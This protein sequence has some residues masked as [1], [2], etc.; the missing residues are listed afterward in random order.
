MQISPKQEKAW[1]WKGAVLIRRGGYVV[2]AAVHTLSSEDWLQMTGALVR[3]AAAQM[4]RQTDNAIK[5]I[6]RPI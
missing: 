4:G 6:R 1:A 2:V 5:P 3:N